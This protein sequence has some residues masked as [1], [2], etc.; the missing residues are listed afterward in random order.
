MIK[1][2]LLYSLLSLSPLLAEA[3][4]Q[5]H[6]CYGNP[7]Q[8]IVEGRIL[9]EREF[10]ESSKEDSWVTNGWRKVKHLIN[11]EHENIALTLKINET[12]YH[13]KTDDEGY[14]EFEVLNQKTP[15]KNHEN[16]E[17]SLD[18]LNTSIHASALI[19]D[20][21]VKVGVISDFDDTVIVSDVTD[22]L[23]LL[24]NTFF[25]NYKQRQVVEGMREHF[26][27]ILNPNTPL[28]F[29][30]GS[31]KQLQPVIHQFLNFHNFPE[32]TLI[33]KKA[34]GDNADELFD[35][36]AYK[37]GKIEKLMILFPNIQWVCFGDSGE[38]DREVYELLAKKYP[39]K[40][41]GIFIRNVESKTIE[42]IL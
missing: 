4:I 31:P 35:Q 8:L 16:I 17:L 6:T 7:H 13:G 1:R 15:W 39:K 9:N 10:K 11:D 5:L 18:E 37:Q 25:K 41:Q 24:K 27:K 26:K 2:S 3:D 30:T 29:V 38:K 42:K 23:S 34:H 32:R 19:I 20:D 40:V 33:T 36:I 28:F 12:L 22:K 21:N 14:F